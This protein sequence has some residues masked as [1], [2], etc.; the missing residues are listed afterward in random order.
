VAARQAGKG[1]ERL[2]RAGSLGPAAARAGRQGHHG[3]PPFAQGTFAAIAVLVVN[4]KRGDHVPG[5]HIL[6]GGRRGQAVLRQSDAP[7]PEILADAFVL[8]RIKSIRGEELPQRSGLSGDHPGLGLGK[9]PSN[10]GLDPGALSGEEAAAGKAVHLGPHGRRQGAGVLAQP[11]GHHHE[12]V[13]G[14]HHRRL[15]GAQ[16]GEGPALVEREVVHHR[17]HRIGE[18][19]LQ[20]PFG[21]LKNLQ[22]TRAAAVLVRGV[23][24][25]AHASAG[26]AAQHDKPSEGIAQL[27]ADL[28]DEP[29]GVRVR[30]PRDDGLEGTKE[31]AGGQPRHAGDIPG[32][33]RRHDVGQDLLRLLARGPFPFQFEQVLLRHHLQDRSDILRHAS[34]HEDEAVLDRLAGRG[35]HD[36]LAE[37]AVTGKQASARHAVFGVSGRR[38]FA[39]DQLD[40]G[41]DTPAVLPAAARSA[42]P[43]AE[44]R[45]AGDGPAFGFVER[46]G[47]GAGLSGG[48]HEQRDQTSEQVRGYSEPGTLGDVAHLRN[49]LESAPRSDEPLQDGG[50]VVPGTLEAGR[51][52]PGGDHRRLEQAEVVL[53]EIE[54]LAQ[55][56]DVGAHTEVDTDEAEHG[57]VNHPKKGADRRLCLLVATVHAQIHREIEHLR[58]LGVVHAEEKDVAPGRVA[59][60]ESDRRLLDQ[61]RRGLVPTS[62]RHQLV[63][64]AERIIEGMARAKHPLVSAHGSHG[65]L[66]LLRQGLEREAM[67]GRRQRTR[68][69]VRGAGA[70]LMGAV[71]RHRFLKASP[72]REAVALVGNRARGLDRIVGG[73]K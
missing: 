46:A 47:Q 69:R 42:E 63:P 54:H 28:R 58:P 6:D 40:A 13:L 20:S 14:R 48:P 2:D 32:L 62:S 1:M 37:E 22:D 70:R 59:E 72:Q 18:R 24:P 57:F 68:Q 43:F 5:A 44:D 12:V 33:Q 27:C 36:V 15:A 29:L 19:V 53:G 41:P 35:R 73:R 34:M 61:Q 60:I 55:G 31:I 56:R 21:A 67:I 17:L 49:D 39:F 64:Q 4:G 3:D 26:H 11:A 50:Q 10:E 30:R 25:E 71:Q 23:D 66:D 9:D 38:R 52:E 7:G 16:G 8:H 65:L 51:N 45:P